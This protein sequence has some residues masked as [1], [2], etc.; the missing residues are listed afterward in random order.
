MT[1]TLNGKSSE[2]TSSEEF[3]EDYSNLEIKQT[4]VTSE[5]DWSYATK[6]LLDSLPQVWTRGLL[7]FLVLFV[8]IVLPWGI[9]AKVDETG[10]ARGRLEPKEK[11][12]KLDAPV[13]ETVATIL[14]RE[15]ETVKAGQILLE[16]KSDLIKTE[17]VKLQEKLLGQ[18]N[19]LTQL[20]LLKNQLEIAVRVQQQQNQAQILEKEAQLAQARQNLE[21]LKLVYDLQQ[22]ERQ[23]QI[24]Q[25]QQT[26]E[27]SQSEYQITSLNLKAAQE[28]TSR[29]KYAYEEGII[30]KDRFLDTQMLVKEN[31]ERLLQARSEIN[32]V[33]SQ[34]KEQQNSHQK[35]FHQANSDIKQAELRLREQENSYQSLVRSVKLALLKIEEQLNNLE[36][37]IS[38]LKSEIAQTQAQIKTAQLQIEQRVLKSPING[39]L[40]DLPVEVA[41]E[42]VQAGSLIAEIAPLKSSLI[43]KAEMATTESGSLNLGM[44][45]KMKFDAYPF[46]DYGI[47]RGKLIKISPTSKTI[48]T[49][50]GS[51]T[52]YE[53]DIE[54]EKNC[55]PTANKCIVL[56]PGDT[57]TAEVIVRQRRVIDFVLDPF[58]KLQTGGL[59][60]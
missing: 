29:Y 3:L 10:T 46:Q 33:Q 4:S 41:G 52:T 59:Q 58:K 60:L 17:L 56:R 43:L 26:L 37:Q 16:L 39:T 11:T 50:Q 6:E 21:T 32:Q 2:K 35:T 48:E 49:N 18:Q 45:V 42:V 40:F 38:N 20:E 24:E 25:T 19:Q 28:K 54:L 27:Q 53:L 55:L 12:I 23:A 7:Y 1:N 22:E 47:I 34:L 57:A 8:S 15:G 5:D 9:L 36:T 13:G 30:S 31:T 44:P 14:V 51:I